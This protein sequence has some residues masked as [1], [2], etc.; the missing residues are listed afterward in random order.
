MTN[1]WV[2]VGFP[3]IVWLT[4]FGVVSFSYLTAVSLG[5]ISLLSWIIFLSGIIYFFISIFG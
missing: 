3:S 5:I 4:S 1:S 2:Y